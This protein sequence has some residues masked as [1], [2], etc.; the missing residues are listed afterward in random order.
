M[1]KAFATSTKI[2]SCS[3]TSLSSDHSPPTPPPPPKKKLK[4]PNKGYD[5]R[6][7]DHIYIFLITTT[8]LLTS[9][10]ERSADAFS[11]ITT[12]T[13]RPR[14]SIPLPTTTTTTTLNHHR[15]PRSLNPSRLLV[16]KSTAEDQVESVPVEQNNNN[17]TNN[18]TTTTLEEDL[19]SLPTKEGWNPNDEEIIHGDNCWLVVDDDDDDVQQRREEC[20]GDEDLYYSTTTPISASL[21]KDKNNNNGSITINNKVNGKNKNDDFGN[22]N[23]KKNG[24]GGSSPRFLPYDEDATQME[25]LMDKTLR[26]TPFFLPVLAFNLYDPT[27]ALFADVIELLSNNNNWVAVDGGLYQ[28][29]IIAPAI[30]GVVIACKKRVQA[31]NI[32]AFFF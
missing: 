31:G 16:R 12:T 4:V 1:T 18:T 26:L 27:A 30:N 5:Y 28:A 23:K 15:H 7:M 3:Q 13:I 21:E 25:L 2:V 24:V 10:V 22:N 32:F 8:I 11:I 14:R 17:N 19:K 29:T 6:A 9:T 20:E